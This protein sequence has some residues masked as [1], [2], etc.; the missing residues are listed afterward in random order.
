MKDASLIHRAADYYEPLFRARFVRA[1][2]ALRK[3]V[4]V[5]DIARAL[6]TRQTSVIHSDE[7]KSV[8][9]PC[10][11]VIKDAVQRGGNIGA[12]RVRDL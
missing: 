8:L 7:I 12:Q 2:M 6:Q 9:A 5:R 4:S 10:E 11:S 3:K 1:M